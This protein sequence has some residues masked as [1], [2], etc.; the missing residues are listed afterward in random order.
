M[1]T[2]GKTKFG[3]LFL[4][5]IMIC[6]LSSCANS[7]GTE[8]NISLKDTQD[9]QF[10]ETKSTAAT[11]SVFHVSQDNMHNSYKSTL[12]CNEDKGYYIEEFYEEGAQYAYSTEIHEVDINKGK[13]AVLYHT[14]SANL[15][16][17][18]NL[19]SK[20]LYWVEYEKTGEVHLV[21]FDPEN[22]DIKI[23]QK[24]NESSNSDMIIRVSDDFVTWY[25]KTDDG[26]YVPVFFDI[27][28]GKVDKIN[29]KNC[30]IFN[31]YRGLDIVDKTVTFF[32]KNESNGIGICRYNLYDHKSTTYFLNGFSEKDFQECFSDKD[33]IGWY[34]LN[35]KN[36]YGKG[37]FYF[38]DIKKKELLSFNADGKYD[39]FSH[40]L[41]NDKFYFFDDE[42]KE[43]R[44]LN[45]T[46]K[47]NELIDVYENGETLFWKEADS[48][49]LSFEIDLKNELDYIRFKGET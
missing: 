45:L 36:V 43:I 3:V 25:E 14:D 21:Q 35:T 41:Q 13:D 20:Y 4:S 10:M 15:I 39:I 30:V 9:I 17:E 24:V 7:I 16:N 37:I 47:S 32:V 42:K 23:I 22:N 1:M 38:Y 29:V 34:C 19:N 40:I 18:F 28:R 5:A 12:L 48:R 26:L 33:Y 6:M 46:D 2:M 49:A 27:K 11:E 44:C 31:P 8:K